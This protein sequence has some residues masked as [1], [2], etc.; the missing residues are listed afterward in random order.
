MIIFI[1]PQHLRLVK[2]VQFEVFTAE[3]WVPIQKD[4]VTLVCGENL[5]HISPSLKV[6]QATLPLFVVFEFLRR[7]ASSTN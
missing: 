2:H 5:V 4:Q 7:I 3:D 6:R 1:G